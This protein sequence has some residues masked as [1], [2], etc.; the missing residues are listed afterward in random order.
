MAFGDGKGFVA[1]FTDDETKE[2]HMEVR[3][4]GGLVTACRPPI[5]C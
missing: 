4:F 3:Q 5:I 1:L 2:S